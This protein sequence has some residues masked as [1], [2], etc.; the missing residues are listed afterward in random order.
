MQTVAPRIDFSVEGTFA[1]VTLRD[2][3]PVI[4]SNAIDDIHRHVA[5]TLPTLSPEDHGRAKECIGALS[6]LKHEMQT[7]KPL[8]VLADADA[9]AAA[10][11]TCVAEAAGAGWYGVCWL[12]AECY[13]YRRIREAQLLAGLGEHDPFRAQKQAALIGARA[14]ASQLAGFALAAKGAEAL[15]VL[16][17]FALWG[18]RADL[19]LTA[20]DL[21]AEHITS[22]VSSEEHLRARADKILH[23]DSGALQARLAGR[24]GRV[25]VV[26]D[27]A[28]LELVADLVLLWWLTARGHAGQVVLHL[29]RYPWFVSDVTAWDLDW[30]LTALSDMD[31]ATRQIAADCR[32]FLAAGTWVAEAHPFWTL[33]HDFHALQT[34]A[35]DLHCALG[36]CAL[37][38]LKGDL[39]YRKLLGDRA[40][41]PTTPFAAA[42]APWPSG[43]AVLRTLK[44]EVIAG[45]TAEA[46]ERAGREERTW[47]TSGNYAVVQAHLP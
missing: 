44:S 9:D 32:S 22:H 6:R 43:F 3:M 30:T 33:P 4:L 10:W 7:G 42:A 5:D 12:L 18:N 24:L 17:Q 29:K 35:P 25:A 21:Q 1:Y 8:R 13:L 15:P 46:A 45:L 47:M 31:P 27:N 11:N 20:G 19:S 36:A 37:T 16:L 34:Q 40:W 14:A 41:A 28:G 38:L 39:N 23:D 26:L 2:R